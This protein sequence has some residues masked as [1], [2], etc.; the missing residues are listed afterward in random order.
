MTNGFKMA[1][2]DFDEVVF[3]RGDLK[4]NAHFDLK[5]NLQLTM[6]MD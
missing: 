5:S 2:R 6:V 4:V 3:E 1:K